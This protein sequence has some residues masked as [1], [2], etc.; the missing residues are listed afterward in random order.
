ME[1][2]TVAVKGRVGSVQEPK[3][4]K[5]RRGT[6]ERVTFSF[7]PPRQGTGIYTEQSPFARDMVQISCQ[8]R[9]CIAL[10]WAIVLYYPILIL[11]SVVDWT[12]VVKIHVPTDSIALLQILMLCSWVAN[13]ALERRR[14]PK[15]VSEEKRR[16]SVLHASRALSADRLWTAVAFTFM[17]AAPAEY[18]AVKKIFDGSKNIPENWPWA[19]VYIAS[20]LFIWL[21]L[22]WIERWQARKLLRSGS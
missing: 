12:G 8:V 5:L 16:E 9:A 17:A 18:L 21:F 4:G 15:I 20:A 7:T 1:G 6:R 3:D 14:D 2:S 11:F 22:L 13:Y 10:I 19:L